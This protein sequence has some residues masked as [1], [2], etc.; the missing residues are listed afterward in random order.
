MTSA[1][2]PQAA[3]GITPVL[4][5]FVTTLLFPG[6]GAEAQV[7]ADEP[8]IGNFVDSVDVLNLIL[9][10]E[11]RYDIHIQDDEVTPENFETISHLAALVARKLADGDGSSSS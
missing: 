5:E 11:E 6:D 7:S 10:I 8:L 9:F 3:D 2:A 1:R 4:T